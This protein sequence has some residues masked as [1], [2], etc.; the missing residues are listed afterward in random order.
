MPIELGLDTIGKV[1]E[2]AKFM[3]FIYSV[4]IFQFGKNKKI[5]EQN[6]KKTRNKVSTIYLPH[7]LYDKINPVLVSLIIIVV[8]ENSTCGPLF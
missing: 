8:M 6:N 4:F 7:G 1:V 2:G 3:L 5:R